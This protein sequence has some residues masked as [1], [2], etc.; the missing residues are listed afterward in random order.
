MFCPNTYATVGIK[1]KFKTDS[2]KLLLE[3]CVEHG[4]GRKYFSLDVQVNSKSIGHIE[5]FNKVTMLEDYL[6]NHYQEGVFEKE[7]SLGDG[8]KEV[9]VYMPWSLK[10]ILKN[11][12]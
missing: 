7:I 12:H 3:I 9:C 11:D 1:L 5:N 2:T 8:I 10:T 6:N 4:N